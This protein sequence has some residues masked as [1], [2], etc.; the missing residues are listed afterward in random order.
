MSKHSGR[1]LNL[2]FHLCKGELKP[3]YL[4]SKTAYIL[5][6]S[7]YQMAILLMYNQQQADDG[8]TFEE[9]VGVTDMSN[10]VM[11]GQLGIL[12]KARILILAN[13]K[14][15]LNTD[16]KSKKIRVNLNITIKSE[17]KISDT[18]TLTHIV[19]DR[20]LVIQACIVRIMKMRKSH[21]HLGLITDVISQLAGRFRVEIGDIKKCIDVLLE[22]EYIERG[23]V[24]DTYNYVA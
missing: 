12:T 11:A 17:T 14:Y 23:D 1:K 19:E 7:T 4:T 22:K 15:T 2:L 3:L 21:L 8:Y 9:F 13:N 5:Q 16:F 24:K 10:E 6:V 18:E 20:K